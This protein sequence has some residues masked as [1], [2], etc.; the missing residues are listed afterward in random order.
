MKYI[1]IF[2]ANKGGYPINT[3]AKWRKG[4]GPQIT[5]RTPPPPGGNPDIVKYTSCA[6]GFFWLEFFCILL[7]F[8]KFHVMQYLTTL[9]DNKLAHWLG[10]LYHGP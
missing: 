9:S 2:V 5:S 4:S 7:F 10:G 3:G 6:I 8:V 1:F